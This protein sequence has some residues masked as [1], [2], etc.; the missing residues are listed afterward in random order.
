MDKAWNLIKMEVERNHFQVIA[1]N[2]LHEVPERVR[3]AGVA[4][5][6]ERYFSFWQA[7]AESIAEGLLSPDP[8][9]IADPRAREFR[10]F[11]E[12]AGDDLQAMAACVRRPRLS[13]S[14]AELK[15]IARPVLVVCG[16]ADETSGRPEPLAQCFADGRAVVVPR[17]N[18]HSTVG[19]RDLK[20][21]AT[22]FLDGA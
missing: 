20:K 14:A 16:E 12:R 15:T 4:G 5:V 17:R 8:A 6:G 18:H 22:D 10:A 7:G 1:I 11:C 2:L 21:A 9:A 13:F 3:R 19:D